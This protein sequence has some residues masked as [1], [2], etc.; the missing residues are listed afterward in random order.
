MHPFG[1]VIANKHEDIIQPLL[2]SIHA[3]I[4]QPHPPIILVADNHDRSYGFTRISY[5]DK[6]FIFSKAVNKGIGH[7]DDKDVILV[8]DD[9]TLLN[10]DFFNRLAAIAHSDP[11]IGILS[12]LVMGCVGG[13]VQRWHERGS[14]WMPSMKIREVGDE[15]PVCFPCVFLRR[16]MLYHTGLLDESFIKYGGEDIDLC[17]RARKHLWKTSVTQELVVQHGDGGVELGEG[18]GKTWSLSY[19]RRML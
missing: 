4:P 3:L 15:S 8:N 16:G 7:L 6:W 1:V 10:Y 13:V 18:R 17:T 14:Q 11:R 12:P 9:V 19:A 5:Q 2:S